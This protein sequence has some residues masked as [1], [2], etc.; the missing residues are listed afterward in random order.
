MTALLI[1]ALACILGLYIGARFSYSRA[2]KKQA[3]KDLNAK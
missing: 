3:K 2:Q 1:F